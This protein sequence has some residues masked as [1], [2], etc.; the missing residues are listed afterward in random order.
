M[1]I[2]GCDFHH[3]NSIKK[4]TEPLAMPH[5]ALV[6]RPHCSKALALLSNL[7]AKHMIGLYT[8]SDASHTDKRV[9][10]INVNIYR[11]IW[12]LLHL[13]VFSDSD[14]DRQKSLTK[15]LGK[16]R[17]SS[18]IAVYPRS[19]NLSLPEVRNYPWPI[20]VVW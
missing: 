16:E 11:C 2:V 18:E 14:I 7:Q 3:F 4:I 8:G 9:S 20:M 13:Q 5:K 17:H 12:I 1:V 19:I 15:S 10:Q 6:P